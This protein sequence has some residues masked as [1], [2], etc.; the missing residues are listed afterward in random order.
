MWVLLNLMLH[1]PVRAFAADEAKAGDLLHKRELRVLADGHGRDE[2]VVPAVFGNHA[3][4]VPDGLLRGADV[5]LHALDAD[6]ARVEAVGAEDGA[7][8]LRAAGAHEAGEPENFAAPQLKADVLEFPAP[9][10]ALDA[11]KD[12]V[13]LIGLAPLGFVDLPADHHG[14]DVVHRHVAHVFRGDE[15]AVLENGETVAQFHDLLEP[16][17]DIED[18]RMILPDKSAHDVEH[19][20]ALVV[21]E[22]RGRLVQDKKFRL[23]ID[24]SCD[25]NDGLFG[26]A[27]A[28]E[29]LGRLHVHVE[30]RH[31]LPGLLVHVPL[32][33]ENALFRL[34]R[35]H[36]D[37][38]RDAHV[39]AE[40]HLLVNDGK[41]ELFGLL[42]GVDVDG[43]AADQNLALGRRKDA[44]AEIDERGLAGAVLPA[45]A[46]D[47]A[48]FNAERDLVQRD[49]T[50]KTLRDVPEFN[51]RGHGVT[52][53]PCCESWCPRTRRE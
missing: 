43:R 47:L 22:S 4:S 5:H 50:G 39:E 49:G 46:V 48:L 37:I 25:L 41:A 52:S 16:V 13:R 27:E 42:D 11:Q 23:K 28:L 44:A 24:G 40:R 2:P 10:E 12:L 26:D 31:Q 9:R 15:A 17:A 36:E 6:L 30:H 20:A 38:V 32:V 34:R 45:Q 18:G 29:Q 14:D 7:Q 33:K 8:H 1:E 35:A 53:S 19:D 51:D 21:G 3:D